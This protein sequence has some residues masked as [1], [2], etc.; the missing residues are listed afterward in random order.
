MNIKTILAS[1]NKCYRGTLLT[2]L[3]LAFSML[4]GC[5]GPLEEYQRTTVKIEDDEFYI[6]EGREAR[7][8][9]KFDYMYKHVWP[10]A[11]VNKVINLCRKEGAIL[12]VKIHNH[13][14][15]NTDA[16][17]DIVMT[18][19]QK[20]VFFDEII[21]RTPTIYINTAPQLFE[22]L[23]DGRRWYDN[24]DPLTIGDIK[25]RYPDKPLLILEMRM[26]EFKKNEPLMVTLNLIDPDD[27]RSI[28]F[29]GKSQAAWYWA[30]DT[31][32]EK[33]IDDFNHWF[34]YVD[35]YCKCNCSLEE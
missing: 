1:M 27:N 32:T 11:Q 10:T 22:V 34:W 14:S 23:P 25:N 35:Q 16:F 9:V 15:I 6:V 24:D 5:Y 4:A 17:T 21:T 30:Q 8:E 7:E 18:T 33:I 26:Q 20:N 31:Q 13:S 29:F 28:V 12:Y 3:L 2:T 19:L